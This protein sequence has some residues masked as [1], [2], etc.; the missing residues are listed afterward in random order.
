M[1]PDQYGAPFAGGRAMENPSTPVH[2]MS[3]MARSRN[4]TRT[5]FSDLR[6]EGADLLTKSAT[7]GRSNA[8]SPSRRIEGTIDRKEGR[9]S[10]WSL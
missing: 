8:E 4:V 5:G 9:T 2:R 6:P 3:H 7:H 10:E 1:D